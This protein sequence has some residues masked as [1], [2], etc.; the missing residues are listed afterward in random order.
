[1]NNEDHCCTKCDRKNSR[2]RWGTVTEDTL[3]LIGWRKVNG[4]LLCPFCAG[5]EKQLYKAFGM[6]D[7]DE[8]K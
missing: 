1:M 6:M 7:T 5:N 3:E 4:E 2:G 8:E